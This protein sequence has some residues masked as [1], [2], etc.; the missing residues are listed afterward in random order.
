MTDCSTELSL[1]PLHRLP[2]VV[3][4]DG[5]EITSD[6]GVLLVRELDER[7]GLSKRL[8]QCIPDTRDQTKVHHSML[9][10]L[11]QRVYQIACG[12]E[13]CNDADTMRTDAAL[14]LAVGKAPHEEDLASQPTLCR[15][16]NAPG[17]RQCYRISEAFVAAYI[18]RH[19][20]K[21]PLRI[22]LDV[23]ATDDECHGAQQLAFFK[24]YYD[25][26]CYLPLLVFLL[27]L[28]A[29]P[30]T[31]FARTLRSRKPRVWAS[32]S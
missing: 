31:A 30:L 25:E 12:Y 10:L 19:Q 11:R 1:F 2:V 3:R 7:L 26:H 23:D 22:V 9:A 4:D 14:K 8:V 17:P 13:D 21:P 18:A 6:A 20:D 28:L 15:L 27:A 32:R 24:D 5:G 16:E 29:G